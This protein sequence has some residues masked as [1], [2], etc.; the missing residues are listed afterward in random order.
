MA[1]KMEAVEA[2]VKI[3]EKEGLKIGDLSKRGATN[4]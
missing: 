3:G 4:D 2:I 1:I